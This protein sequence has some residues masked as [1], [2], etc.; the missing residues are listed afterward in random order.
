MILDKNLEFDNALTLTVTANSTNV[1]DLGVARDLAAS[2]SPMKVVVGWS[3]LPNS[4]T[5]AST[6][7]TIGV[8]TSPDNS[9]WTT[10]ESSGADIINTITANK[11]IQVRLP[12]GG[13]A[14]VNRYIR[15]TYTVGSGP[16]T[17]GV[18]YA[19]LTKDTD[20]NRPAQAMYPRNYV[21]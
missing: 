6:T 9:T 20:F 8:Q 19:Y 4:G 3:T 11:P 21:A 17:A 16:L 2:E 15:L 13:S 5:P 14:A 10:I 12:L 18:L 1:V 7:V